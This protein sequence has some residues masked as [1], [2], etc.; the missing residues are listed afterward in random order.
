ME[1]F[2]QKHKSTKTLS[3]NHVKEHETKQITH[4]EKTKTKG[5]GHVKEL[6]LKFYN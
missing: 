5:G 3:R 4:T 1:K 2:Q 6:Q